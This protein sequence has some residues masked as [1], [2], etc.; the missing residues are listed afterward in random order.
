MPAAEH[1]QT[2]VR[3][4]YVLGLGISSDSGSPNGHDNYLYLLF[5]QSIK[6]ERLRNAAQRSPALAGLRDR[7]VLRADTITPSPISAARVVARFITS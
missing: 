6:F 2:T 4:G 3:Y 1:A 7:Q 5:S